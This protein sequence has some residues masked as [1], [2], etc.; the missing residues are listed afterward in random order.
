MASARNVLR[1]GGGWVYSLID[2]MDERGEKGE[3]RRKD[4]T[5]GM[6]WRDGLAGMTLLITL[7]SFASL[8]G[9]RKYAR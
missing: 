9:K 4:Y 6:I 5:G 2:K 3:W 1:S 7:D 8:T